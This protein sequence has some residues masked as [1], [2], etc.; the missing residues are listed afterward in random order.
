VFVTFL[1]MASK[2]DFR[3]PISSFDPEIDD[4]LI[5]KKEVQ[6]WDQVTDAPK[7]KRG[8]IIFWKL[9]GRAKTAINNIENI[10][11]QRKMTVKRIS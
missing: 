5:W 4:Y 2:D 1:K 6:L 8:S 10:D 11:L 9:K 3:C 7:K